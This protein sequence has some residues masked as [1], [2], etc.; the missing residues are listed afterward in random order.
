[1]VDLPDAHAERA[2]G[3]L[4]DAAVLPPQALHRIYNRFVIWSSTNTT[5]LLSA[6]RARV[7]AVA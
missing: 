6:W 3:A 5:A 7:E 2:L 1:M 4:F